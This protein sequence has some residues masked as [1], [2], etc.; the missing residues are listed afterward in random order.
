MF[1]VKIKELVVI[2][3]CEGIPVR[4]YATNHILSS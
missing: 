3:T 2:H 4:A 1:Y